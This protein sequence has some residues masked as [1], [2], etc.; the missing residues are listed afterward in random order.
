MC[1]ENPGPQSVSI[2]NGVWQAFQIDNTLNWSASKTQGWLTASPSVGTV[3][4]TTPA[5][6]TVSVNVAGLA[7]GTYSDV[8]TVN[9]AQVSNRQWERIQVTLNITSAPS[10]SISGPTIFNGN[11]IVGEMD[12]C[13]A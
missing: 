4:G 13:T 9:A 8:F 7:V 5:S 12:R 1:H 10:I 3:S 6:F 2:T 11:A